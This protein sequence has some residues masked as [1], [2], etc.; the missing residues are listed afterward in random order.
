MSDTQLKIEKKAFFSVLI[1]AA[2]TLLY[3]QFIKKSLTLVHLSDSFFMIGLFFLAIG[4]FFAILSSGFF[5]FFQKNMKTMLFRKK[6]NEPKDF[7]PWSQL[8]KKRPI[9]WF[10]VG[11]IFLAFAILFFFIGS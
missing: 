2:L 9:Y 4:V 1:F 6:K 10:E 3:L 11:G 8:A 7:I 5:D